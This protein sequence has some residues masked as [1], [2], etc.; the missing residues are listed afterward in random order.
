MKH[1]I[2]GTPD[3]FFATTWCGAQGAVARDVNVPAG[4][5]YSRHHELTGEPVP[6]AVVFRSDVSLADSTAVL[7]A[8][9]ATC[10]ECIERSTAAG[11]AVDVQD[12]FGGDRQEDFRR[13]LPRISGDFLDM[14]GNA[15]NIKRRLGE[16]D[17]N[18]RNRL[19]QSIVGKPLNPGASW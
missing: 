9:D 1:L 3:E 8:E 15:N 14:F 18:Y 5:H 17:E 6:G 16:P 12:A 13:F 2:R 19:S 4:A 7:F 11:V 10:S